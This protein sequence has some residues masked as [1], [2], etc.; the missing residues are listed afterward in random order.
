[1]SEAIE[2]YVN[3]VL[4]YADPLPKDRDAVEHEVRDHLYTKVERLVQ[5]GVPLEDAVYR[6]VRDYGPA[7]RAGYGRRRPD[8]LLDIRIEGTARG[9]VAIGPRAVGVVAMGGLTCGVV[10]FGAVSVGVIGFGALT[11]GLVAACG[12]VA[13]SPLLATGAAAVGLIAVGQSAV[14][15]I[16]FGNTAMGLVAEGQ[17]TQ[18]PGTA[19]AWIKALRSWIPTGGL[20]TG[21]VVTLHAAIGL[22]TLVP[23]LLLQAREIKRLKRADPEA[24]DAQIRTRLRWP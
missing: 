23:C 10:S 12:A 11:L 17:A 24:F 5:D 15:A 18:T 20:L 14:G 21:L 16:A 1:M 6:A 13:A 7:R 22:A 19:P 4:T 2:T 3:K 8:R 9:V